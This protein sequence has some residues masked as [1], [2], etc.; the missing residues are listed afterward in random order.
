[1]V[2]EPLELHIGVEIGVCVI[3]MD[4]ETDRHQ[5]VLEMIHEGAAAGVLAERPAKRVG[6][7]TP[8]MHFRPDLPQLLHAEPEFL[9]LTISGE[10]ETVDD[11][12]G[13]RAPR[14]F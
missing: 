13:E 9:R 6:D 14:S 3:E 10:I 4:H 2:L 5:I 8:S 1:M 7:L 11:A 12:P